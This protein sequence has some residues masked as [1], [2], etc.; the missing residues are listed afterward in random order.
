MACAGSAVPQ[1]H[2]SRI[3]HSGICAST[4]IGVECETCAR[5]LFIQAI[6]SSPSAAMVPTLKLSTL[7]KVGTMAAL[8]DE[9]IAWIKSDLAHVSHST[10]IVVLARSLFIQDRKSTRL[11][12]SHT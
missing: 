9:Q 5:S 4:T 7:F 6:C 10:P 12:S 2:G 3:V 11:N 8:G 1:P